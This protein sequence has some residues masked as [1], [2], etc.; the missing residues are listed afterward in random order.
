[1]KISRRFRNL[2]REVP[3]AS[4]NRM[5]S[6]ADCV[7]GSLRTRASK[8]PGMGL[9]GDMGFAD[10]FLSSSQRGNPASEIDRRHRDGAA[11][12]E[13]NDA[14]ALVHGSAYFPE[15]LRCWAISSHRIGRR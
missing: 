7:V 1:M 3:E 13:G 6:G 10:W 2:A 8:S 12:T 11:W 15:L 9:N 14:R 4:L 5:L